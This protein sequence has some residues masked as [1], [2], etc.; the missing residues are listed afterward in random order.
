MNLQKSKE[1]EIAEE[2]QKKAEELKKNTD[3]ELRLAA[4]QFI[5]TLKHQISN[6]IVN[7]QVEATVQEAFTDKDF[8]QNMILSMLNKWNP[9]NAEAISISLLLPKDEETE[10]NEF[11]N[12]KAG[13]LKLRLGYQLYTYYKKRF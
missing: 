12:N 7:A 1:K 5:S 6:E 2:I 11:F 4:R 8:S 3:S 9:E 13:D 10:L